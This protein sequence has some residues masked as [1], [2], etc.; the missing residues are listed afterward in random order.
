M[1]DPEE[2]RALQRKLA[3]AQQQIQQLLQLQH[4]HPPSI[5]AG[6]GLP[7]AVGGVTN[8]PSHLQRYQHSEQQQQHQPSGFPTLVPQL[9]PLAVDTTSSPPHLLSQSSDQDIQHQ[10]AAS[11]RLLLLDLHL[12]DYCTTNDKQRDHLINFGKSDPSLLKKGDVSQHDDMFYFQHGK[13]LV[14]RMIKF[15]NDEIHKMINEMIFFNFNANASRYDVQVGVNYRSNIPSAEVVNDWFDDEEEQTKWAQNHYRQNMIFFDF[16]TCKFLPLLLSVYYPI[17]KGFSPHHKAKLVD[18]C[19]DFLGGEMDVEVGLGEV[20]SK[21]KNHSLKNLVKTQVN[22]LKR[23]AAAAIDLVNVLNTIIDPSCTQNLGSRIQLRFTRDS[24]HASIRLPKIKFYGQ[25]GTQHECDPAYFVL[26]TFPPLLPEQESAILQRIKNWQWSNKVVNGST[27]R[28]QAHGVVR[29]APAAASVQWS[30]PR[31]QAQ[32]QAQATTIARPPAPVAVPLVVGGQVVAAAAAASTHAQALRQAQAQGTT[33]RLSE[34]AP[35]AP[36]VDGNVQEPTFD[37]VTPAQHQEL[38]QIMMT[39]GS[40][41]DEEDLAEYIKEFVEDAVDK[42]C[43]TSSTTTKLPLNINEP[44]ENK[45]HERRQ[46]KEAEQRRKEAKA[47]AKL[48]TSKGKKRNNDDVVEKEVD[49]T[50][51]CGTSKQQQQQHQV[52]VRTETFLSL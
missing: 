17:G 27:P 49:E 39:K 36:L 3:I 25:N 33:T 20:P 11:P 30:T 51:T 34:S 32:A 2:F 6:A 16:L 10:E 19:C 1:N 12:F 31:T 13:Q 28:T 42:G 47:A 35:V 44:N 50:I 7:S 14:D 41:S 23:P 8:T 43:F 5:A 52:K 37:D 22:S 15:L 21:K 40:E 18:A 9:P 24:K 26:P 29:K 45:A 38:A 4:G 48:K 46:K